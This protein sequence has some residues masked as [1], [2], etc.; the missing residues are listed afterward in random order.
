MPDPVVPCPK[1]KD[2]DHSPLPALLPRTHL[3][4]SLSGSFYFLC[5]DLLSR[6]QVALTLPTH[7]QL[8]SRSLCHGLSGTF[9]HPGPSHRDCLGMHHLASAMLLN[10]GLQLVHPPWL[11][12]QNHT[13]DAAKLVY[14]LGIGLVFLESHFKSFIRNRKFLRPFPFTSWKLSWV[15]SCSDG[16]HPFLYSFLYKASP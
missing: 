16:S 3:S 5:S 11:E 8:H 2:L 9:I 12:S 15:G 14:R 10:C 7:V 13:E 1:P 6:Y 4:L